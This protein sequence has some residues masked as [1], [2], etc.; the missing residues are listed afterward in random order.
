MVLSGRIICGDHWQCY[1]G[2]NSNHFLQFEL[3][4]K[5]KSVFINV[6]TSN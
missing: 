1:R 2:G 5:T 6:E 3:I 4:I